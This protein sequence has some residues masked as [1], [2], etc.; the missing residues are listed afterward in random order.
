MPMFMK[1]YVFIVLMF[2][3]A[4]VGCSKKS[5]GEVAVLLFNSITQGDV[6][7]VKENI[8]FESDAEYGVFCEYLD[9]VVASDNFKARTKG[10]TADYAVLS[11][12]IEGDTAR[13][14]LL[15]Y[16]V[17]G[18]K[19]RFNVLLLKVDGEWKVDGDQ[20]VIHGVSK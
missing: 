7:N 6:E 10:Y 12:S 13:V 18:Q 2:A 15:G 19:T 5:P 17:L 20:A 3:L 1:R 16:T 4:F 14:E 11:E 8:H 9:M